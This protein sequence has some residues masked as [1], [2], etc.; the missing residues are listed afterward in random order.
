M[1]EV[2]RLLFTRRCL[3]DK[4]IHKHDS[5][6]VGSLVSLVDLVPRSLSSMVGR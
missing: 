3:H 4:Y 5:P 2:A 6:H 1:K